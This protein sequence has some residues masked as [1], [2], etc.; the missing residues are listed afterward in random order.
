MSNT[1]PPFSDIPIASTSRELLAFE[2]Q[3]FIYCA[4]R[5]LLGRNPD[6][7]GIAYYL[8]RL[9]AGEKKIQ[10]ILEL[11]ASAEGRRQNPDITGLDACI[12]RH[13]LTNQFDLR[14]LW[15]RK[16]N[17]T[18]QISQSATENPTHIQPHIEEAS[19]HE[20]KSRVIKV[21]IPSNAMPLKPIA[22]PVGG[23]KRS[24]WIDLTLSM[25]WRGDTIEPCLPELEIAYGFNRLDNDVRFCMQIENGFVEIEKTQLTWL[26]NSK[27]VSEAFS[28]YLNLDNTKTIGIDQKQEPVSEIKSIAVRVPVNTNLYFPFHAHDVLICISKL[29]SNRENVISKVKSL[30]PSLHIGSIVYESQKLN[31]HTAFYY[32]KNEQDVFLNQAKWVSNISD[33]VVYG[34]NNVR[35]DFIETQGKMG[36]KSPRNRVVKPATAGDNASLGP[37]AKVVLNKYQITCPYVLATGTFESKDNFD[38][39][40]KAFRMGID[41]KIANFPN[42]VLCGEIRDS[43][44]DLLDSLNRDPSIKGKINVIRPDK[45]ELKTLRESCLFVV[46]PSVFANSTIALQESFAAN[47]FCLIVDTPEAREIGGILADY[48]SPLDVRAWASKIEHYSKNVDGLRLIE[49]KIKSDWSKVSWSDSSKQLYKSVT[50]LTQRELATT[51]APEIWFDISTS[52]LYWDGGV[53]G[54]I[55]AELTFAKYLYDIAPNSNNVHFFAWSNNH[56]FEIIPERLQWLFDSNDLVRDY[57][58]FQDFW[59]NHHVKRDPFSDAPP[60]Q[61]DPRAIHAFPDNAIV[62]FTCVDWNMYQSR[63]KAAVEMRDKGKNILLSQLIYDMTPFLVP[64]LHAQATCDGFIPFV[65]YVSNHFN[66]LIYGGRTAMRDTIQIQ[67][68]NKWR[69]PASDFIEFGSDI[70][71]DKGANVDHSVLGKFGIVDNFILTVGTIEPRKNHEMLYKAYLLMISKGMGG[72]MPM[73]VIVGKRGWKFDDFLNAFD[74]DERIKGKILII[75]PSD[76]ELDVLYR[77]CLFTVLPSFYEGWS[78]T[79]PESLSYGKFCLTSK[80]DPLMETGREL[81]EYIDPF[82]TAEWANRIHFYTLNSS[83]LREKE[84]QIAENWQ[85]KSWKE[86]TQS[87]WNLVSEA[88]RKI[89]IGNS[90]TK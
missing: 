67:K 14:R 29:A 21:P 77:K 47:K 9:R 72:E 69:T 33:F 82:D 41:N 5:S 38:T 68:E 66:H 74:T 10:I 48:V 19:T 71:F 22:K 44:K 31:A 75:S 20:T 51:S 50:E 46:A 81:V 88:H 6:A 18:P 28:T 73:L 43:S 32:S 70:Q 40:Y 30:L 64:H 3:A 11:R 61:L 27:S 55:R 52:Y 13:K 65:E 35:R 16:V 36:W 12:R 1:K 57:K 80:V 84:I 60:V 7:V 53:A 76:M 86:S 59:K 25:E 63:V 62:I 37:N 23:F 4:Y 34:S 56:F 87:L 45:S 42:L 90:A 85:P 24:I 78:L 39:I 17:N 54:I 2:D 83:K 58:W 49:T 26:L 89:A 15:S 8:D 79:L